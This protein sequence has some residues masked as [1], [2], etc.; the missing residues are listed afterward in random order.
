MHFRL[1]AAV[2]GAILCAGTAPAYAAAPEFGYVYTARTEEAGETELSLWATDRRGKFSGHYAGQDYR[3]EVERGI[4]D[5][6]QT[7]IYANFAGHQIRDSAP[8]FEPAHRGLAFQGVSAE[9][10]YAVREPRNGRVGFAIY[11]EPGWARIQK[12]SGEKGTEY[13]IE[14]KAI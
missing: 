1:R 11:A 12:V 10:V 4:T 14:L 2:A 13:E 8:E 7:S 5:R 3:L 6:F 9:F